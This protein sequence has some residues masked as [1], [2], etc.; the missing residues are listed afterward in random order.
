MS[1]ASPVESISA[2]PD[3][4]AAPPRARVAVAGLG[5]AGLEHAMALATHPHLSLAGF[6]EPRGDL[7]RF[8]RGAGFRVPAAATL[9]RLRARG[10]VDALVVCAPPGA[11]G[12]LAEAAVEADLALLVHGLAGMGAAEAGRVA[13]AIAHARRPVAAGA[14]APFQPLF[15]RA[16][17]LLA[18]GTLGEVRRV[19]ASAHVAR[20][21]AA[22]ARPRGQ[23]VLGCAAA[24]LA[25]LV[26]ALFGPAR[27]VSAEGQRLYGDWYDEVH[28]TLQLAS[29]LSLGF[30][31]SWS[32]PGYPRVA[33]VVEVDTSRGR[34]LV[35]DEVLETEGHGL[36]PIRCVAAEESERWPFEA[37]EASPVVDEFA[38]L[39][40]GEPGTTDALDVARALRVAQLM[41]ALRLSA[42]T[43]SA[44]EVAS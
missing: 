31:A 35:S 10:E 8:A 33:L 41:E 24:P 29:G 34:L 19:R 9:A 38:R 13:A 20:V 32:A 27:G 5:R 12:P 30:D 4:S 2:L 25:I 44:R 37:G 7:R 42:V 40:A 23:D 3:P 14:S 11:A 21:F 1:S 36:K 28:A 17:A 39:L 22:G 15:R 18:G 16:R 43:G 26:D 6:V